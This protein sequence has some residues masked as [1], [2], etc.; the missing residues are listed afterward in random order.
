[1]THFVLVHGAF[2][3][4]WAFQRLAAQ[5]RRA[6]HVVYTPTLTGIG[7]RVH[8]L[9]PETGLSTHVQ[10][11]VNVV[12]YEDLRD[13][14]LVGHSYAG[15]V[16][17]NVADRL[18]ERIAKLVYLDSQIATHGQN[19]MGQS[20]GNT[21]DKLG[22]MTEST[23]P[24]MLPPISLDAMGI[25]DAADRAWVEGKLCPLP[26]KCLLDPSHL[27]HGDPQMPRHYVRCTAR[28]SMEAFFQGDPLAGFVEKAKRDGMHFHEI[29]S[30]HHPMIT[31]PEEL[32][33]L[34]ETIAKA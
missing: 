21:A 12:Q 20:P 29:A 1:M 22:S 8:L 27:E 5:L 4:G 7:E 14:V 3:G 24:Q 13:V 23:G 28:E 30:G 17:T 2:I 9:T 31:H 34:L 33:A 26:M 15:L 10:D 11:I 19:A 18:R 25:F 6:G 32:A 16:V